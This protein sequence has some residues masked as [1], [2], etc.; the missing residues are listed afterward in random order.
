MSVDGRTIA[1]INGPYSGLYYY[2]IVGTLDAGSHTYTIQATDVR[3]VTTSKTGVFTVNSTGSSNLSRVVVAEATPKNGILDVNEPLKITWAGWSASGRF[4]SQSVTVDRRSITPINGPYAGQYYSCPIG[5]WA[6]GNH[7]YVIRATDSAGYVCQSSG[8]FTVVP[9][10]PPA[11]SS[12]VV[13]E[14][15]PTQYAILEE[16]QPLKVTWAASAATAVVSQTVT[17]DGQAMTTINGP[18]G[19]LYYS[20][21]IGSW[22]A[23]NHSYLIQAT[24]TRGVITAKAGMFTVAAAL[25]VGASAAPQGS[26]ATISDAQSAPIASAGHP[27]AGIAVGQPGR[28]RHG[29]RANQSG[30]SVAGGSRG[31]VGQDDLDRR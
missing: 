16:N 3:G 2:C 10:A 20:C 22:A 1:P 29:R 12:V 5:T 25:T 4:T 19:K 28:N 6:A 30:E 13:A 27:A 18:Y 17:V 14:S 11:I 31:S 7:S 23:G 26:A 15:N 9:P 24:D 8:T 21:Q